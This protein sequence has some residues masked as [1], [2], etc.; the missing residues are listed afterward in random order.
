L[1][2]ESVS[3]LIKDKDGSSLLSDQRIQQIVIEQAEEISLSQKKVIKKSE[4]RKTPQIDTDVDLYDSLVKEIHV[5]EDGI[6]VR[7]QKEIRDK[8]L[9]NKRDWHYTDVIMLQQ[10]DGSFKHIVSGFGLDLSEVFLSELKM[11]YSRKRKSLPIVVFSDGASSIKDRMQEVL[12]KNVKRI[13]DWYHLDK[14]IWSFM[15]MIAIN[16]SEKEEKSKLILHYLWKGDLENAIRVLKQVH[17]KNKEKQE[18]LINYLVKRKAEIINYEKRKQSGKTIGSGRVE[19]G[20][21]LIVG[22]RQKGESKSW[23]A[24]G[25]TALALVKMEI[26]NNKMQ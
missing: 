7:G 22:I 19:K 6:G 11:S 26:E 16:K 18:D 8:S 1:S 3:D 24:K 23:S 14:K 20:C 15:S 10:P 9:K 2:Y 12:G 13:L 25:S 17:S 5:F 21:D 4:K